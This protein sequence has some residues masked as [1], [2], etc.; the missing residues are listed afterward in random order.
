MQALQSN[1]NHLYQIGN[2]GDLI[3]EL[4]KH[5]SLE[6]EIAPD[7]LLSFA[8]LKVNK[9]GEIFSRFGREAAEYVLSIL[10]K[11]LVGLLK[12][13]ASIYRLKSEEFGIIFTHLSMSEVNDFFTLLARPISYGDELID[14]QLTL[15]LVDLIAQL[16]SHKEVLRRAD[17]ALKLAKSEPLNWQCFNH[18]LDAY[19]HTDRGMFIELEKAI[20][21]N[22]LH[23]AGQPIFNLDTGKVA[24][25]E[26]LLRWQHAE[27]GAVNPLKI[28]ELASK[29]D[30]LPQV[31]FYVAKQ[32]MLFLRDHDERYR[33]VT[34]TLNFNMPQIINI[35]LI[36][37]VLDC[38]EHYGIDK[39]R[40][41]FEATEI[42][43][44]PI[45]ADKVVNHF[46]WIKQ[47][48][49]K[50]AIDDFGAG[51]STLNYINS[52][53]VDIIKVDRSL[54]SDLETSQRT[55]ETLSALLQLC[56]KLA[57][58]IVVEGIENACQHQWI[59]DMNIANILVQGYFYAKPSSLKKQLFC[60]STYFNKTDDSLSKLIPQGM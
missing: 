13:D 27:Y 59:K 23:L 45:S 20:E 40:F 35:T 36:Q 11:R 53:D 12:E 17:I 29:N 22:L 60:T 50:I 33:N 47:Q 8:I 54:V 37:S 15:G 2:R 9:H 5:F 57:V 4:D 30:Y 51:Y 38:F 10:L 41:V 52:L 26:I 16:K 14:V 44:C 48:G 46:K 31:G 21:N 3:K 7:F 49:I 1:F 34:F 6:H 39:S 18:H 42:D 43:S 19:S 25:V 28:I 56:H 32:L 58:V 24:M 55:Q